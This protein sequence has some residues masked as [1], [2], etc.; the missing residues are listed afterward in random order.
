[1]YRGHRTHSL[2]F[3]RWHGR[4]ATQACPVTPLTLGR[5]VD[6]LVIDARSPPFEDL[7]LWNSSSFSYGRLSPHEDRMLRGRS[8]SE[9]VPPLILPGVIGPKWRLWHGS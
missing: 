1:M 5:R 6:P 9:L 4:G 3:R 8:S 7:D 2:S